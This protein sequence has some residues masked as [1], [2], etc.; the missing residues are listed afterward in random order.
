MPALVFTQNV[1]LVLDFQWY[2][3]DEVKRKLSEN[4]CITVLRYVM[5]KLW[6]LK[7]F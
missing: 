6:T 1:S 2:L 3:R 7:I 4:T 5:H